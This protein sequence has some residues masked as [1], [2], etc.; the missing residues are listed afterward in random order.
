MSKVLRPSSIETMKQNAN[1]NGEKANKKLKKVVKAVLPLVEAIIPE[2]DLPQE[3]DHVIDIR[4][5]KKKDTSEV[6]RKQNRR[7]SGKS[8]KW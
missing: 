5:N 3:E 8:R 1:K 4:A 7:I 2:R 6:P